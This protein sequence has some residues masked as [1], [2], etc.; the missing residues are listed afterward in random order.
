MGSLRHRRFR[1]PG[2]RVSAVGRCGHG[3]YT[4]TAW[5]ALELVLS[6]LGEV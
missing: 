6:A 1:A 3:E 4:P 5:Y 2:E